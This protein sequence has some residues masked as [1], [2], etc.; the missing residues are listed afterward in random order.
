M[1]RTATAQA[2]SASSASTLAS[3]LGFLADHASHDVVTTILAELGGPVPQ[4]ELGGIGQ[5]LKVLGPDTTASLVI[6]DISD[7]PDGLGD[8]SAL[9]SVLSPLSKLIV[10]GDTNDI[11]LY[12]NLLALGC[13]DYLV[14]PIDRRTF[15]T[16]VNTALK[17]VGTTDDPAKLAKITAFFGA[18]GGIGTST[19]AATIAAILAQEHQRRVALVDLDLHFGTISLSLG[20]DATSGL[21]EA[22]ERPDRLDPLFIE[23]AMVKV[24]DRLFVLSSEEPLSQAMVF[25]PSSLRALLSMMQ[26]SFD[27][28]IVDVP[29][30]MGP[31][32]RQA[33]SLADQIVVMSEMSLSGVRDC[34]R[35]KALL[36]E[37]EVNGT[38][39][40]MAS[41]LRGDK[42]ASIRPKE[43]SQTVGEKISIIV[44]RD[45]A[46]VST[47]GGAGKPVN[48]VSRNGRITRALRTLARE[49][50]GAPPARKP[51]LSR[52]WARW[53][54]PKK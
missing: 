36:K 1:I 46:A 37:A 7:S 18:R 23:R 15:R 16:V 44:P 51:P 32:Q 25:D 48:E 31:L 45:D 2:S 29:R 52:F 12:R 4:V 47:A 33:L 21:R 13:V 53:K 19:T 3:N 42:V 34:L 30:G 17:P 39:I 41:H 50:D 43:F 24:N 22:L 10:I 11:G 27:V 26:Q 9:M 38:T 54:Q 14:K 8:V 35:V 28:V 6:V 49:L 5:A 20:L 40:Y